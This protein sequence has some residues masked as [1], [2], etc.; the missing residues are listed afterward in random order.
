M[1]SLLKAATARFFQSGIPQAKAKWGE[2][3]A[4]IPWTTKELKRHLK[5]KYREDE[6]VALE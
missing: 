4:R 1:G 6:R 5:R 2:Q 3:L